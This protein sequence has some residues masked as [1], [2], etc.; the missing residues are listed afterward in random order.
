MPD[1]TPVLS[2]AAEQIELEWTAGDDLN[3][4]W[5]IEDVDWSGDYEAVVTVAGQVVLTL[6][7]TAVYDD[8]VTPPKTHFQLINNDSTAVRSNGWWKMTDTA[9]NLTRFSG[10]T[11][12]KS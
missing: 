3:F 10:P 7:V 2:Q 11:R 1:P 5:W 6:Q 12:V 4:M 9:I 8:T